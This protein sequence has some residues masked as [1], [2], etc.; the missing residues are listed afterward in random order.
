MWDAPINTDPISVAVAI[1]SS[2]GAI[3][4]PSGCGAVGL[5]GL[6]QWNLGIQ[7]VLIPFIPL[8][9]LMPPNSSFNTG[10]PPPGARLEAGP[11]GLPLTP[12][13]SA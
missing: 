2:Q 1:C 10:T 11:G 3:S 8:K 7:K 6:R 9:L 12:D 4:P 5:T 13:L